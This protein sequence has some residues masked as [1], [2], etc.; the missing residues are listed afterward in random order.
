MKAHHGACLALVGVLLALGAGVL[1]IQPPTRREHEGALAEGRGMHRRSRPGAHSRSATPG[2]TPWS[3]ASTATGARS[4]RWRAP[5]PTPPRQP[6]S[7]CSVT[8]S[9]TSTCCST[10]SRTCKANLSF[11]R[12]SCA[13]TWRSSPRSPWNCSASG[14]TTFT[15]ESVQ[16]MPCCSTMP[17]TVCALGAKGFLAPARANPEKL[18]TLVDL[19][20]LAK[21]LRGCNAH[22]TL[23]LLDSCFS[24]AALEPGSGVA[25][26]VGSLETS[27]TPGGGADNLSRVF[28][29]RS[30]QVITAGAG[31]EEVG[32]VVQLA[33]DYA[34]LAQE[35]AGVPGPFAVHIGAAASP[36]RTDGTGR[37]QATGQRPGPPYERRPG[38]R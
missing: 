33:R 28:S 20:E 23:V 30:F 35:G 25:A 32:D 24:G 7:S 31:S 15:A 21:T 34:D 10:A 19:A 12:R 26:A 36:A 3:S 9:R 22:H 16:R 27:R 18:E 6:P 17:A 1:S 11:C 5:G 13:G 37:R 8:D 4:A 14:C 29:R 38:Q 2:V